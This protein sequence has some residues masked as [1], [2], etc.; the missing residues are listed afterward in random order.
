MR[1]VRWRI[2]GA[3]A[4]GAL[5]ASPLLALPAVAD[6]STDQISTQDVS[7][8]IGDLTVLGTTDVHGNVFNWD[9]FADA[10]P[11]N[12]ADQRGLARVATVVDQVR[13]EKEADSVLLVDNG[14]FI[15]GTPLTYL[16]AEQPERLTSSD[17]PMA[18]ALNELEYDAQNLG[19]HEFNYGLDLL[20]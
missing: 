11:A 1:P 13:A 7:P 17:H 20:K 8:T 12:E 19:N 16:A 5:A 4:V 6:D 3:V 2:T 14:D 15:Q 10:T 18:V 9:Y